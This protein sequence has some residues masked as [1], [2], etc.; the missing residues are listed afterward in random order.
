MEDVGVEALR[1][2]NDGSVL[3]AVVV[4][5]ILLIVYREAFYWPKEITKRET[6]LS[7][8]YTAHDATRTAL[9]EEVRSGAE[10]LVLVREQLKAQSTAIDKMMAVA[11]SRNGGGGAL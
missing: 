9:L 1:T 7:R 8:A 10:T 4:I 11:F 6:E 2:L 5:L 3:G